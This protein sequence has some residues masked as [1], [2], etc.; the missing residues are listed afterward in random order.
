MLMKAV[1]IDLLVSLVDQ[2]EPLDCGNQKAVSYRSC[3]DRPIDQ[4]PQ[5][6]D[7]RQC[8]CKACGLVVCG[9]ARGLVV[10]GHVDLCCRPRILSV[11]AVNERRLSSAFS[12]AL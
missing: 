1:L 4:S 5:W 3:S 10:C 6:K 7:Q 2:V 8:G 12:A 9:C 11:N